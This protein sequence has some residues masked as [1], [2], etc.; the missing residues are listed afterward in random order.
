MTESAADELV[1]HLLEKNILKL[2]V[3]NLR[4]NLGRHLDKK[5]DNNE[6][7]EFLLQKLEEEELILQCTF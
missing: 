4:N 1:N 3:E 2:L 5:R 6:K 7:Q